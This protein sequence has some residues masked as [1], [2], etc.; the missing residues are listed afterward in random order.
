MRQWTVHPTEERSRLDKAL[1]TYAQVSRQQVKR[2]LDSG[3]VRVNGRAVVIAKWVVRTGDRLAVEDGGVTEQAR[4]R[5]AGRRFVEV[6]YEDDTLIAVDKPP[7]M[8]VVPE[9]RT[10]TP[11]VVDAVRAYL[12]RKYP[13]SRGTYIRALHRLDSGTSGIVLLAKSRAGEAVIQQFKRYSV[14][15]DYLAIVQGAVAREAGTLDQPVAKGRFGRGRKAMAVGHRPEAQPK[16]PLLPS[17][18]PAITHFTVEERYR[19]ATLLNIR[20]ET[21]RTHQIRV[22]LAA[23]G[24]PLVGDELYGPNRPHNAPGKLARGRQALHAT[25]LKLRHPVTGDVVD[26]RSKLPA[27]LVKVIDTFRSS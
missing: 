7:G 5:R 24:H 23:I 17:G 9:E 3:V 6:L 22:H 2:W 15:R 14:H 27:D 12:R 1:V 10:T 8:I 4:E 19:A 20:V 21:G 18:K 25:R 11:T 16:D 26:I 13:S